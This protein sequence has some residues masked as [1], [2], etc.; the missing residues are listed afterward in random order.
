MR[1]RKLKK[2]YL[3]WGVLGDVEEGVQLHP[4]VTEWNGMHCDRLGRSE[5]GKSDGAVVQGVGPS[6][7]T[8]GPMQLALAFFGMGEQVYWVM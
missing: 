7:V 4:A 5:R 1:G 8:A 2:D 6:K 3:V